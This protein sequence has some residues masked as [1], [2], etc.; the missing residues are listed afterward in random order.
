MSQYKVVMYISE[1][2]AGLNA[3]QLDLRLDRVVKHAPWYFS[4]EE[5]L[6]ESEESE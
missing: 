6:E 3:S 2:P 4:I 5:I 1:A